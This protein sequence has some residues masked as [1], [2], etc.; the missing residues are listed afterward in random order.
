MTKL[1]TDEYDVYPIMYAPFAAESRQC[2]ILLVYQFQANYRVKR[3]TE[4]VS[5]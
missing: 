5:F 3:W 1:Y 4:S 2:L